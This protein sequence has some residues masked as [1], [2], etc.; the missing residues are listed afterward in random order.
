MPTPLIPL[1]DADA[2]AAYGRL[3]LRSPQRTPFAHLA[4]ADAAC[5]AFGLRGRIAA[6]E[7][8]AGWRGAAIVYEKSAGPVRVSAVPPLAIYSAPILDAPLVPSE[9]HAG[10]SPLDE[11]AAALAPYQ[12]ATWLLPP[13]FTDARPLA[14][15]GWKLATRYTYVSSLPV[16]PAEWS[17]AVR[18]TIRK[19]EEAYRVEEDPRHAL[20]AAQLMRGAF[21]RA[22][23]RFRVPDEASAR[24]AGGLVDAG[25]AR[26]FAAVPVGGEEPA[27]ALVAAHNGHTAYYW[28]VG[29]EHGPATTL[30]MARALPALAAAGIVE[31]DWAGAN[32]AS[33]AEF[34]R[35]FGPRLAPVVRARRVSGP[36]GLVAGLRGG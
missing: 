12:Q 17:A 7:G 8:D 32:V 30:L 6:V 23:R 34:K 11:L 25:L 35:R 20:A 29:G 24:I 18:R 16:D 21:A 15:A 5:E 10:E 9:A 36:L 33:V 2:R 3:W 26:I 31:F 14:W 4:F 28:I 22:G 1:A 27:A 13:A 19:A